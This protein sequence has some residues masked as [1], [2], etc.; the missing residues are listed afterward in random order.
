MARHSTSYDNFAGI[1]NVVEEGR[2]G[3]DV[4]EKLAYVFKDSWS[5]NAQAVAMLALEEMR[6]LFVRRRQRKLFSGAH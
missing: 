5:F 3:Q 4:G 6:K 2:V 1:V